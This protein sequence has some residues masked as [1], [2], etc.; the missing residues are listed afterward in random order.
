MNEVA[1][2]AFEAETTLEGLVESLAGHRSV[3]AIP[4]QLLQQCMNLL[5][6]TLNIQKV[7]GLVLK[8][9]QQLESE[10]Q[11]PLLAVLFV[12]RNH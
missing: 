6:A 9:A 5:L 12:K 1:T 11:W 4:W 3:V 10:K 8:E 7:M 2:L